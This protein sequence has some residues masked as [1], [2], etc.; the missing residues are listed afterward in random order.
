M[1]YW[2]KYVKQNVS[3][4]V[5]REIENWASTEKIWPSTEI[6]DDSHP[7]VTSTLHLEETLRDSPLMPYTCLPLDKGYRG[8]YGAN[9][10]A[11]YGKVPYRDFY[12]F[13]GGTKVW[14]VR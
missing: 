9:F 4:V 14:E 12:H 1:Y 13:V 10:P 6:T 11:A 7:N 8:S 2:A 3:I 5:G